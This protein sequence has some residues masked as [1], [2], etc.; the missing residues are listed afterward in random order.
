MEQAIAAD[1]PNAVVLCESVWIDCGSPSARPHLVHGWSRDER[2]GPTGRHFVWSLGSSS[3]LEF[4]LSRRRPLGLTMVGSPFHRPGL[5]QQ[6]VSLALNGTGLTHVLLSPGWRSHQVQLPESVQAEGRNT[7]T[8]TYDHTWVPA[9]IQ[10]G[11][12]D[13]R[14]LA[15]A[16][17][18]F[19]F[20][21]TDGTWTRPT[22]DGTRLRLPAGCRVE[23][24]VD[25][26][27]G[28]GFV[29]RTVE[30]EGEGEVELRIGVVPVEGP[31]RRLATV[32]RSIRYGLR[33]D[34]GDAAG[35]V[36]LRLDTVAMGGNRS[37][38]VVLTDG[39]IVAP[40]PSSV[41]RP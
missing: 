33:I 10:S 21:G 11:S 37:A 18:G 6:G 36:R 38:A 28:S 29:A 26:S 35:Q 30:I 39:S 34:L 24:A 40:R 7:L 14:R 16:W 15:V 17:D 12:E 4:F 20:G 9:E 31:A 27:R 3:E 5:D 22:A 2:H 23:Y 25:L 32:R 19:G 41:P 13:R 8:L 1:L